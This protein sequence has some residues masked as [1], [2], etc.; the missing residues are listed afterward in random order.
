MKVKYKFVTGELTEVEVS[1]EIG[2]VIL[3]SRREEHAANERHRY[4][5]AFSL[6]DM[7]YED[8]E[9]F[10]AADNPEKAITEK[11]FTRNREAM[12]SQLTPVQRRRFEMF[13]SGMSIADIARA[14]NAAFNSVKESVASARRKL[15]KLL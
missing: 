14:E 2:T 12:L 9:Y 11:E 6:D 1:D 8:S 4:H 15:K 3:D 7:T 10:S 13:E 5:T